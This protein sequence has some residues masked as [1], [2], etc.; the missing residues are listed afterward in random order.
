M[1]ERLTSRCSER[2][3]V[4][5]REGTACFFGEPAGYVDREYEQLCQ[6]LLATLRWAGVRE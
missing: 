2:E 1:Q 3:S 4:S 5:D 6:R